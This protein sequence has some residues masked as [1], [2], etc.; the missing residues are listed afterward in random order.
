MRPE[1][2]DEGRQSKDEGL[3]P[4]L[5]SHHMYHR[6]NGKLVAVGVID[7]MN[8][9]MSSQYFIYDLDYKFLYLGVVGAVH[10]IE[11]MRMVQKRFNPNLKHYVLGSVMLNSPKYVYK[12]NYRPGLVLCPKTHQFMNFEEVK[13][14]IV[15]YSRLPKAVREKIEYLSL[16]DEGQDQTGQ[17][18]VFE[19]D[20]NRA[21][22]EAINVL[23]WPFLYKEE[24]LLQVQD[25]TEDGI[26]RYVP[27]IQKFCRELGLQFMQNVL[28]EL[29]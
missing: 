5:G 29:K 18:I 17:D 22:L 26:A 14:K 20:K 11:Y 13:A 9:A 27:I 7:I 4:G 23:D 15:K 8:T 25:L 2:I 10:E 3:Y 16:Q 12:L 19:T 28:L 6:I 1:T 21:D 24:R